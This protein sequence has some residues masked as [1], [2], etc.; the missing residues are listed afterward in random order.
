ME[1]EELRLECLKLA[2][3]RT[4]DHNEGLLRAE[5]FFQFVKKDEQASAQKSPTTSIPG[6]GVTVGK[7]HNR[8]GQG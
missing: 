4:P 5:Q 1:R 3:S 2:V 8:P 6:A 7:D